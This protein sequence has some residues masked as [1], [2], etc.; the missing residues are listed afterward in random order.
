MIYKLT[1]VNAVISKIVDDLQIGDTEVPIDDFINWIGHALSH[2]G[3][4]YQLTEKQAVISIENYKG[5]LPCDFYKKSR[6]LY[7]GNRPSNNKSLLGTTQK[8]ISANS[9]SNS[10]YNINH[11][12]ITTAFETGNITIQYLALPVDNSGLPLV[13]DDPSFMDALF[14][15]VVYQLSI[16]G[17][18]FKAT[19]LRDVNFTLSMWNR[20]CKQARA[21]S[22]MPDLDMLERLKN[23]YLRLK[24]DKNQYSKY[25]AT[26]GNP[27]GL[28]LNGKENY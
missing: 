20:Y 6:T 4:Y 28:S 25:F 11:N 1:S 17:F 8:D 7:N 23:N 21:A 26:N 19:Q 9:F 3:S 12:V 27:E 5:E 2:I 10:D 18:E 15:R 14:W 24:V 13:P 22:N 16:R